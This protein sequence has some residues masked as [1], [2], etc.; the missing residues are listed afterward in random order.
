MP[1][2]KLVNNSSDLIFDAMVEMV[3]K[4]GFKW[5]ED[6]SGTNLGKAN[7]K[8]FKLLLEE[9]ENSDRSNRQKFRVKGTYA[10]ELTHNAK[11]GTKQAQKR[12]MQDAENIVFDIERFAPDRFSEAKSL[13]QLAHFIRWNTDPI[14]DGDD[15]KIVTTIVFEITYVINNPNAI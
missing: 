7:N 5:N 15:S 1:A 11:N 3:Q 6:I 2:T 10:V 12:A 4:Q 9:V 13:V 8:E 14:K